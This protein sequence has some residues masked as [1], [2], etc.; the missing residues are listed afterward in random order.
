MNTSR[1]QGLYAAVLSPFD[2]QGRLHL[3]PIRL[4]VDWLIRR[5][6]SGL[7]VCGT[8]GEG[9]SLTSTERLQIVEAYTKAA[10]GK[11]PVMVH[12]GHN[13]IEEACYF[14]KHA[15]RVGAFAFSAAPPSYFPIKDVPSLVDSV[16]AIAASAPTL[17]FYY[18]HIP[19]LTNVRVSMLEFLEMASTR[20]PNLAGIKFTAPEIDEFQ[21]CL[22]FQ[23]RRFNMLWGRDEMLMSGL[24]AGA[25][26]A[27]G[28]TYN[29]ASPL[30]VQIIEATKLG[31]LKSAAELQLQAVQMIRMIASYP[32]LPALK[33][34]INRFGFNY[35]E[36]RLP[37]AKLSDK[38]SAELKRRIDALPFLG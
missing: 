1:P 21:E 17:P 35:G 7:F 23:N 26:A 3:E 15:A 8:T 25:T 37:L 12:V 36:C 11:L 2:S 28:S 33:A 13:S 30:Y 32:F 5:Q 38:Q 4:M 34:I 19:S 24:C 20:I 29:I 10:D 9:T 18:Y 22:E 14:G 6:V 27:V 16:A 31:D